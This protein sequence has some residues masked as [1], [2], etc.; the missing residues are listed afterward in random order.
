MESKE[1]VEHLE[2][3]VAGRAPDEAIARP[4]DLPKLAA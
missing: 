1:S 2:V 3:A 4:A